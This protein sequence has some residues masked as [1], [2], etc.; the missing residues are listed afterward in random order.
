MSARRRRP[1]AELRLAVDCLPRPTRAA[2]LAAVRSETI[3]VGAYTVKGGGVCPMLGAHRRGGRTN[4][5]SFARAWDRYTGVGRRA[6]RAT[7]REL[8]T[9]TAMLESSLAADDAGP[10]PGELGDA[11]AAHQA[12]LRRRFER[13]AWGAAVLA[14][15][16]GGTGDVSERVPEPEPHPR[17]ARVPAGV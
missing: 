11:V 17:R 5:A 16:A 12:T 2:M 1:A 14:P 7:E 10:A 9:L 8:R 6:R 13:E 3:V 15:L 4:L